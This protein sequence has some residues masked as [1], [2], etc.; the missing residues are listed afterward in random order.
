MSRPIYEPSLQRTDRRLGYGNSQLFRRPAPVSGGIIPAFT[1]VQDSDFTTAV[2]GNDTVLLWDVWN[3]GDTSVFDV[4]SLSGGKLSTIELL[5]DGRYTLTC[6]VEWNNAF[7]ATM[8]IIL[9]GD[10]DFNKEAAFVGRA[11]GWTGNPTATFSLIYP[12]PF[13]TPPASS[14]VQWQVEQES[15]INQDTD[16]GTFMQITYDGPVSQEDSS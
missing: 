10:Y 9:A 7:N 4:N 2:S 16:F 5:L 6:G 1:A 14:I 11:G 12:A 15:G 3:N 8:R 13:E